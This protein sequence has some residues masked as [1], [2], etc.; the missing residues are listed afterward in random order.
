MARSPD[1][2][3][4]SRIV[5]GLRN[6]QGVELLDTIDKLRG[7]GVDS[8]I[9]LPQ[10]VV[11]G[12]QSSG[13]SS[14]LEAISGIPFPTNDGL[15]T[16]FPVEVIMRRGVKESVAVQLI[17]KSLSFG[18][19]EKP[20]FDSFY[21]ELKAMDP[22]R[23]EN[24]P[25]IV[26]MASKAL[27]VDHGQAI[28]SHVLRIEVTGPKQD[29][30]TLIDLPGLF[31]V[32]K[33]DKDSASPALVKSLAQRY[34]KQPR[35]LILAIVSAKSD[36]ATQE[37]LKTLQETDP[38][39]SRTMGVI[40]GLD[41][42]EQGSAREKEY[43]AL[44]MNDEIPLVRGWHVLRNLNFKERQDQN[45]DRNDIETR[46]FTETEP[47]SALPT[48]AR[49]AQ[50]L[51]TK[52]SQHL[53]HFIGGQ[54][55][56]VVA[57][58][59]AKID[60]CNKTLEKL[61]PE[62]SN[63]RDK[64]VYLFEIG[65]KH[66]N[67][68]RA[69]LNGPY[70]EVLFAD[71]R[72]R[73]RAQIRAHGD[74]FAS[75]MRMKGHTW[76]IV[77]GTQRDA[78]IFEDPVHKKYAIG[79]DIPLVVDHQ[80]LWISKQSY[81]EKVEAVLV[82]HR[83]FEL[84]GMFDPLVVGVLF[85][86][87]SLKWKELACDYIE[88]IKSVVTSFLFSLTKRLA[89][90]RRAQ[91]LFARQISPALD[92]REQV[93]DLRLVE[94]LKPFTKYHPVT[95]SDQFDLVA[96]RQESKADMPSGDN[97][98]LENGET[99]KATDQGTR[100]HPA[101]HN[102]MEHMQNY[103]NVA[104]RTFVDNVITLAIESC[105]LD[106]LDTLLSPLEMARLTDEEVDRLASDSI[107]D[108]ERRHITKS[109]LEKLEVGRAVCE[110]YD[111]PVAAGEDVQL[112]MTLKENASAHPLLNATNLPFQGFSP[113]PSVISPRLQA[114]AGPVTPKDTSVGVRMPSPS[115]GA[116]GNA[117]NGA[118]SFGSTR[119]I[120][121][122][123]PS[124]PT[125]SAFASQTPESTPSGTSQSS[126]LSSAGSATAGGGLF[127]SSS[128]ASPR[129]QTPNPFKP[130]QR[131]AFGGFGGS[132]VFGSQIPPSKS[133]CEP[134]PPPHKYPPHSGIRVPTHP[135]SETYEIFQSITAASPCSNWSFEELRL[136][137]ISAARG[138]RP[139][140]NYP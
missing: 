97:T 85:R 60:D 73:L 109:K 137:D 104:I 129:Q 66:Q 102:L 8:D 58:L 63:I 55:K 100:D 110:Q 51:K 11:V 32:T 53:M 124:K 16:R 7:L 56:S 67:L 94:L 118:F 19:D 54:M 13:K 83:T 52:L 87:Q 133:T 46:F 84:H 123:Q 18:H 127:G 95:C 59:K 35:T 33:N 116:K 72:F 88:D 68:V 6:E 75:K 128:S 22:V 57:A 12:Q 28:S 106:E 4:S 132:P 17:Y 139:P 92:V 5:S 105:L 38:D 69:A 115:P 103:Y 65:T 36:Y 121:P 130:T 78:G 23:L 62:R 136:A 90:P 47:W 30:L 39:G 37:I 44:A 3:L 71:P 25:N 21:E 96:G 81:L 24:I 26:L 91:L 15:C 131:G 125:S 40:T 135:G 120:S 76:Q 101:A 49:G 114:T 140:P 42:V 29:H 122:S 61:G 70:S 79:A 74:A 27:G 86:N 112:S 77:E 48:N 14:V 134:A 9:P 41:T 20:L 117:T 111:D 2:N 34:M 50:T 10:I 113:A 107:D 45:S 99:S 82:Q 43:M 31:Y 89:D 98:N 119:S 138:L 126:L 64:R 108:I 80:P 1:P 93:L